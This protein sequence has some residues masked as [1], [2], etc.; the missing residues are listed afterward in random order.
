MKIVI[1]RVEKANVLINN[2]KT[3]NINKGLMILAG[4]TYNDTIDDIDYIIKKIINLRIFEDNNEKL[5]LSVQDINGEILIVSQ[6]TLYSNTKNGNRPSFKDSLP[7]SDANDLYDKFI[8]CLRESYN[9]IKTGEFG[10]NMKVSL[11]NDGPVT[12]I[13]DSKDR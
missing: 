4:F 9:N 12:I 10:A 3:V 2:E 6:F 13:I 8:R 11:I 7:Y 1:Q 5:N